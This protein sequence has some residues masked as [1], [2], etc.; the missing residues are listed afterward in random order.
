MNLV[1]IQMLKQITLKR[2]AMTEEYKKLLSLLKNKEQTEKQWNAALKKFY[3][4]K[5]AQNEKAS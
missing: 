1:F 2:K 5:I 3:K 4:S